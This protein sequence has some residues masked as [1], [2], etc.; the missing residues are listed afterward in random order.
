MA[1]KF[2]K[3]ESILALAHLVAHKDGHTDTESDFIQKKLKPFYGLD[4]KTD[5]NNFLDKWNTIK[6]G[7]SDW[8]S[9]V[10]QGCINTLKKC[11]YDMRVK[12]CAAIWAVSYDTDKN[13]SDEEGKLFWR[14]LKALNVKKDD[15]KAEYA[16]I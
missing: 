6:A 2:T 11:N 13:W 7:P 4:K 16:K 5:W 8:S 15:A 14:V 9:N 3:E 1:T 10:E 12:A